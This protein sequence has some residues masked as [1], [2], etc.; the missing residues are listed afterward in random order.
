LFIYCVAAIVAPAIASVLMKDFGPQTLFL[1]NAYVH[2]AIAALALR[3]V[4]ARP[5]RA[6]TKPA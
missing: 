5:R 4:L 6:A 2:L 3:G 1:Q